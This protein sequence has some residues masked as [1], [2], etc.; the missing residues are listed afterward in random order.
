MNFFTILSI[1]LIVS[2]QLSSLVLGDV[3]DQDIET[4]TKTTLKHIVKSG[5]VFGKRNSVNKGTMKS[6][7]QKTFATLP[8]VLCPYCG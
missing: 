7:S 8:D 3:S 6:V 4:I 1:F 2:F 5:N